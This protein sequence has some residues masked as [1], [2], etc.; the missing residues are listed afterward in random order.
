VLRA[1]LRSVLVLWGS[2]NGEWLSSICSWVTWSRLVPESRLT[3]PKAP[4]AIDRSGARCAPRFASVR[5]SPGR[6][7]S[8]ERARSFEPVLTS[9]TQTPAPFSPTRGG[10]GG[11]YR[12]SRPLVA[13]WRSRSSRRHQDRHSERCCGCCGSWYGEHQGISSST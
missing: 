13:C 5:T 8:T 7:R 3:T 6:D 4:G 2:G 12:T 1:D 11:C 10:C 9:L